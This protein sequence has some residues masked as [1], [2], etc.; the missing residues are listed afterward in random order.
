LTNT[1][2]KGKRILTAQH[3]RCCSVSSYGA[4]ASS[5]S[6]LNFFLKKKTPEPGTAENQNRRKKKK[7]KKQTKGKKRKKEKQNVGHV[8]LDK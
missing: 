1:L 4:I 3:R 7:K 6:A 8:I 2:N 5:I